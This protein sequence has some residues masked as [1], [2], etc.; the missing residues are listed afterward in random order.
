MINI[1]PKM[2]RNFGVRGL[3]ASI[4]SSNLFTHIYVVFELA[5][6]TFIQAERKVCPQCAGV[7]VFWVLQIN[8]IPIFI[9]LLFV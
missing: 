2:Q 1:S 9:V 5:F 3:P 4:L 8:V 6:L 7:R